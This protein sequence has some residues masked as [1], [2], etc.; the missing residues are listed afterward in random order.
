[1]TSLEEINLETP[2]EFDFPFPPYEIQKKF[3]EKLYFALE[4]KKL[5]IFESPTGT[6]SN[7]PFNFLDVNIFLG[8]IS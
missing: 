2:K 4:Q 3:M 6:V 8:Q 5:G 7:K 1:M